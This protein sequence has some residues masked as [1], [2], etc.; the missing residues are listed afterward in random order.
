ME[1]K[2]TGKASFKSVD[3]LCPSCGLE[4]LRTIDL[5]EFESFE[6]AWSLEDVRC[7]K[8][9]GA[10]LERVWSHAPG[11]KVA[12]YDADIAAMKQNSKERFVKNEMDSTRHKFGKTFDDAL[13]SAAAGRIK[14]GEKPI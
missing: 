14:R 1:T 13:V 10:N 4:E 6:A 5:R 9:Q 12:D 11:S 8:C 2:T 3:L 7:P